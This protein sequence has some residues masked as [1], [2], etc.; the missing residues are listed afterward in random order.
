MVNENVKNLSADALKLPYAKYLNAPMAKIDET[1]AARMVEID[2]NDATTVYDRSDILKPGYLKTEM[3]YTIMPDG[4]GFMANTL[5]MPGVTTEMLHWW[6]AWHGLNPVRYMIWDPGDHYDVKVI[7]G[8]DQ[9]KDDKLTYA[10]R[11]YGVVHRVTEDIGFGAQPLDIYFTDPAKL[12]YDKQLLKDS[13]TEIVAAANG[14]TLMLHSA[15]P[16]DGGVELRSRFWIGWNIDLKTMQP[17]NTLKDGE[18]IDIEFP[19]KLGLHSIKE[20]TQLA[21]ILPDVFAH[22]KDQF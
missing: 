6:F 19:H 10:Q 22:E 16:I 17:R 5:K 9:L 4:T 14:D 12:G 1:N 20:M 15:R 2:P 8:T 21:A 7:K 11:L 13:K 18:K 3:G